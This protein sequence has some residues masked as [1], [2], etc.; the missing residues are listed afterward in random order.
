M[1]WE[2]RTVVSAD[3]G[4]FRI[5]RDGSWDSEYGARINGCLT[6]AAVARKQ[7]CLRDAA[8]REGAAAS[9]LP[10][11]RARLK[12]LGAEAQWPRVLVAVAASPDGPYTLLDGNHRAVLL[13]NE[14]DGHAAC[15]LVKLFVGVASEEGASAWKYWRACS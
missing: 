11:H 8:P 9:G 4:P 3:L 2:L 15:E 6:V 7:N 14:A 12:N 5:I 13:S 1:R 10:S